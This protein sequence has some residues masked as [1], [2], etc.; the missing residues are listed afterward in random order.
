MKRLFAFLL[1]LVLA[2][3]CACGVEQGSKSVIVPTL[4]EGSYDAGRITLRTA[5]IAAVLATLLGA[6][7]YAVAN[8]TLN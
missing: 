7:A 6:T 2:V 1:C 8:F 4:T 5:L 3:L